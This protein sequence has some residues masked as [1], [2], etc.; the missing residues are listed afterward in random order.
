VTLAETYAPAKSRFWTRVAYNI[1]LTAAGSAF[2]ALTAQ[3]SF[4]LP[5]TPVPITG[6]TLGV[7]L[8]AALLGRSRGIAAVTACLLEGF[9]GLP[10]FSGGAGGLLWLFGPTGG[11]L[12]GFLPAAFVV[13]SLSESGWDKRVLTTGAAMALG[14]MAIFVVGV[15]WLRFYVGVEN[16]LAMGLYPFVAGEVI[17]IS[18]ATAALPSLRRMV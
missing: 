7:L 14:E 10:V 9:G 15:S 5:F 3:I 4:Q 12:L 1:L 8:T 18:L 2:I 6:Q 17:K 16:S 13:G 11:Y